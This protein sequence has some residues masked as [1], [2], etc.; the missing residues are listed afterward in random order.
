MTDCLCD[1]RLA[2]ARLAD[3]RRVA[4]EIAAGCIAAVKS[5]DVSMPAAAAEIDLSGALVLPGLTDGHVHLD[6][7][8]LGSKWRPH[9]SAPSIRARIEDE[10]NYRRAAQ[11]PLDEQGARALLEAALRHGTTSLRTHVDID[12]VTR[13]DHLAQLLDLRAR[14][15]DRMQIQIVAFPQSG[16]MACPPVAEYL[17]EALRMGADLI[18]GLDP[19]GIDGDRDGQLDVVFSLA[20]RHGRAIDI[21]LHDGGPAGLDEI[22][23]IV[24]RT[25]A[26]GLSGR[27][28]ISHAF[29]LADADDRRLGTIAE[30]LRE[31][32]VAILSS[33]PGGDRCPPIPRLRE[34][35]VAVFFGSDNVRDCWNPAS[36]IGM[37]DRAMLATYRF[38]LRR[39]DEIA[40]MI[41]HV[42]EVPSRAAGLG[43][44]TITPGARAD[45]VIFDAQHVPQI[46]VERQMPALIVA[47]GAIVVD[48]AARQR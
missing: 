11:I 21:H 31:A 23:A 8:M 4:I 15:A 22:D 43:P 14:W 25:R 26:G 19:V 5:A 42:T 24:D 46:V 10:K 33:I 48:R 27:V 3:G 44:G 7:T 9:R 13:L 47:G 41:D 2:H 18:G 37:V 39:D 6:K 35:G 45:L 17:D 16:V 1:L 28:T 32:G 30:A 12:D 38:G 34:L 36:V 20:E 40:S 29:A